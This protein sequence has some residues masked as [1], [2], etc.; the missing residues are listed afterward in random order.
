MKTG[1]KG[2][3]LIKKFE[4]CELKAYH[5]S[6]GVTTIGYGNTYYENGEKVKISDVITKERAE[7]LLVNL[8]PK[9]EATVNKY[10]KRKLDQNEFD[11][12]VSFCWNCGSSETL[13]RLV[14]END[15]NA[16]D[17]WK[18]HYIKANG[19]V[20]NGLKVRRKEEAELYFTKPN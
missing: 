20:L 6:A 1:Q 16:V 11:A 15:L 12:L 8:L 18:T 4:G 7:E 10:I 14:N 3:D 17:W 9:Y 2:I 5:C 13:F 19:K